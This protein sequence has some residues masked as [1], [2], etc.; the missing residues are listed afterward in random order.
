[1]PASAALPEPD[2]GTRSFLSSLGLRPTPHNPRVLRCGDEVVHV[3]Q[4]STAH[5]P[6][7]FEGIALDLSDGDAKLWIT[8]DSGS[9]SPHLSWRGTRQELVAAVELHGDLVAVARPLRWSIFSR[10]FAFALDDRNLLSREHAILRR[11]TIKRLSVLEDRGFELRSIRDVHNQLFAGSNEIPS[12]R[13]GAHILTP[14]DSSCLPS[15]SDEV[16]A[17]RGDA[18][19]CQTDGWREFMLCRLDRSDDSGGRGSILSLTY[20]LMYLMAVR[21]T[22]LFKQHY[23][24]RLFCISLPPGILCSGER[25]SVVVPLLHLTRRLRGG[26]LRNTVVLTIIVVPVGIVDSQLLPRD[27]SFEES[28]SITSDLESVGRPVIARNNFNLSGPLSDYLRLYEPT[29]FAELASRLVER[30]SASTCGGWSSVHTSSVQGGLRGLTESS[31]GT[32]ANLVNWRPSAP[33]PWSDWVQGQRDEPLCQEF[34][35]AAFWADFIQPDGAFSSWDTVDFSGLSI[36]N[37]HGADASGLTLYNPQLDTKFVF[38]PH[39]SEKYPNH[40][41]LRWF[42]WQIYLDVASASVKSLLGRLHE[43]I[44]TARE[45]RQVIAS[46]NELMTE[47]GEVYDLDLLDFFYRREYEAFRRVTRLDDDYVYMK[48]R[49]STVQGESTLREQIL[50]NNMVLALTLSSVLATILAAVGQ[51]RDWGLATYLWVAVGTLTIA[52]GISLG[53]L[54]PTRRGIAR[55]GFRRKRRQF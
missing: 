54:E 37:A 7:H 16:T 17:S 25:A 44:D 30:L 3:I 53:V 14:G 32:S 22:K 46:V 34:H 42:T 1:M 21:R 27:A 15:V 9:F 49:L 6:S 23:G 28:F 4:D 33:S 18:V 11:S 31:S 20:T 5:G 38:F 52:L 43:Q 35:R 51:G 45:L 29:T 48:E 2:S 10:S 36:G 39:K 41:V 13:V 50:M 40:S 47:M 19:T 8:P 55:A 24:S 12:R 26:A